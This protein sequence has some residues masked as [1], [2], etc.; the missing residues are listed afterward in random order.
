MSRKR[1]RRNKGRT[2]QH[3]SGEPV[4]L[5]GG[6]QAVDTGDRRSAAT[7]E[8]SGAAAGIEDAGGSERAAS[9]EQPDAAG[10]V[11]PE[12]RPGEVDPVK[13]AEAMA[14]ISKVNLHYLRRRLAQSRPVEDYLKDPDIR[15]SVEREE[16]AVGMLSSVTGQRMEP[17][18]LDTP[19]KFTPKGWE[20]TSEELPVNYAEARSGARE[21]KEAAGVAAP[22]GEGRGPEDPADDVDEV[23][24]GD[25]DPRDRSTEADGPGSADGEADT[26]DGADGGQDSGAVGATGEPE[27]GGS[28]SPDEPGTAAKTGPEAE[29]GERETGAGESEGRRPPAAGVSDSAIADLRRAVEGLAQ[30]MNETVRAEIASR[31]DAVVEANR[32]SSNQML[33]TLDGGMQRLQAMIPVFEKGELAGLAGSA[34][35]LQESVAELSGKLPVVGE[36]DMPKLIQALKNFSE[37]LNQHVSDFNWG[38]EMEKDRGS[39][40]SWAAAAVAVPVLVAV[41]LFGQHQFEFVPDG[42]N[43]WKT[44][45]WETHGIEVVGCI[46]DAERSRNAVNC[47]LRVRP[48]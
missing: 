44:L 45:V 19:E 43:G 38:R 23:D 8:E 25:D 1:R 4:E 42:T 11:V 34:G 47:P 35:E 39:W 16:E 26:G 20:R 21:A 46:R 9:G 6:A 13:L 33:S 17:H 37:N 30:G 10:I 41:G 27:E 24:Q 32:A 36:G 48:R 5:E 31:M 7:A 14:T 2:S 18:R 22:G 3:E 29:A 40:R 28:G 15:A 12:I